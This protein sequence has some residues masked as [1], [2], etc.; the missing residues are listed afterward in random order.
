MFSY[1]Q[2]CECV[3]AKMLMMMMINIKSSD[4]LTL[5]FTS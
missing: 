2:V 4:W 5:V 1:K 3:M